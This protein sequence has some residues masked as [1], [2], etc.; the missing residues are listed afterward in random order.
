MNYINADYMMPYFTKNGKVKNIVIATQAPISDNTTKDF[1]KMIKMYKVKRIIMLTLLEEMVCDKKTKVC[2]HKI[3][4]NDYFNKDGK[5]DITTLDKREDKNTNGYF[6]AEY[7][8]NNIEPVMESK[9]PYLK[10]QYAGVEVDDEKDNN[11]FIKA[12][13]HENNK[14]FKVGIVNQKIWLK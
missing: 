8:T 1:K 12:I 4:S 14:I 9:L 6:R 10:E 7:N 11:Q 3:R 13:Q 5:T 2:A